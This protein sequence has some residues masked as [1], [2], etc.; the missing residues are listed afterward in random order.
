[1]SA[2]WSL[3]E[4]ALTSISKHRVRKIIAL[5][6][7]LAEVLR[8]WLRAPYYILT[9]ILIANTMTSLMISFFSTMLVVSVFYSLDR[10]I[11]EFITWIGATFATLILGEITPKIFG[12]L[13]PEKTTLFVLPFLSRM[14]KII[15]P[16]AWPFVKTIRLA[17]PKRDLSPLS[18]L[19]HLSIDE[20]KGL[21]SEA[22]TTGMLGRETSL[23]LERA[24]GLGGLAVKNIMIPIDKVDAVDLDQDEEKFLDKVV[25]TGRSRVPVY[26]S[27]IRNIC[28]FIYTK[29]L[30]A[31]W[32]K[33]NGRFSS[34][35]IRPVYF[36]NED[37]KVCDLLSN[38]QSRQTH[39]AVINDALGNITGLVTLEDVLE[40]IV[41]E[42]LDEY[43][44]H[45][46]N[47]FTDNSTGGTK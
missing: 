47:P 24:L 4:T 1:M 20:I 17:F 26:H 29:D 36:I 35:F 41:G 21:I 25:E 19:T 40:E 38:F 33:H 9:T 43:D 5:N 30:L 2:F 7:Q 44:I 6:K 13:N 45:H 10:G 3:S 14:V 28:G 16:L 42:I 27:T 37:M 34:A 15:R 12:R 11:L 8:Q 22:N 31:A 18:R 46:D 23:M 39:M 32:L